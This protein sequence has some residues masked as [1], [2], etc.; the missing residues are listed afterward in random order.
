MSRKTPVTAVSAAIWQ[1]CACHG[2][3]NPI[4]LMFNPKRTLSFLLGFAGL[5]LVS[6]AGAQVTTTTT[7]VVAP[8][9]TFAYPLGTVPLV[10]GEGSCSVQAT[11]PRGSVAK[12][13]QMKFVVDY[14]YPGSGVPNFRYYMVSTGTSKSLAQVQAMFADAFARAAAAPPGVELCRLGDIAYGGEVRLVARGGG[15][16]ALMYNPPLSNG[17]P[18]F[19]PAESIAFAQILR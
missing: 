1:L 11:A 10:N 9:P 7:T 18:I 2:V 4:V 5:S 12:G 14:K 16:T 6:M 15:E 17:N 19:S 8:A 3:S 13:Q